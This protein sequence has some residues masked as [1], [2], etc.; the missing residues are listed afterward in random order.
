MLVQ[1]EKILRQASGQED[2]P[3]GEFIVIFVGDFQ[4][5]P[6]VGN[7]PIPTEINAFTNT[8]EIGRASC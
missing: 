7:K 8:V 6:P 1:I 4:Q 2:L 5:L 3:Y